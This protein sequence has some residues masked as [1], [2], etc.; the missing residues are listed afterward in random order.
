MRGKRVLIVDDEADFA[1]IRFTKKKGSDE[2]NQGRIANQMDDLRRELT[3]S[4]FL[5]VTATPYALYLQP[6]EYEAPTG[7]NLTFEPKRPAFTKLVPVH[8]AYI[9]GDHYF[10]DQEEDRPE[11]HLWH[12]VEQDEL[13]ALK[14]EDR[15]RFVIEDVLS[16][17]KIK[18]LRAAV[19]NF[20][21]AGAIRRPTGT[22]VPRIRARRPPIP[23]RSA[24]ASWPSVRTPWRRTT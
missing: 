6:D 14:K 10:G 16:T 3:R 18:A 11:Y 9:G 4:S 13:E 17:S 1:S 23:P 21:T 8:D 2:I 24:G 19:A 20:V 12:E 22:G 15:R 5:Q 7:A